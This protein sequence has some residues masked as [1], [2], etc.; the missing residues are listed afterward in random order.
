MSVA[1]RFLILILALLMLIT[2]MLV[3]C[4]KDDDTDDEEP[5]PE[6]DFS[7]SI[8]GGGDGG[9]SDSSQAVPPPIAEGDPN[10][11]IEISTPD[12]LKAIAQNGTYVLVND[13]DMTGVDFSPLGNYQYPFKGT[14]KSSD[15]NSF[16]I[17]N[18]K[19]SVSK[20]AL[21]PTATY[22]YVYAGLF[23]ATNGATISNVNFS[24]ADI[25]ATSS[26]EYSLVLSGILAGYMINTSVNNCNVGGKVYSSSKL[27][28]AYA[29]AFSG[30]LEGGS[31]ENS[32][33]DSIIETADS[34]NRAVSGGLA[35]LSLLSPSVKHCVA[36]GT[37]K[38]V[39]SYG[40]SYAGGLV[41]N[42][43]QAI[44]TACRSEADVYAETVEF[45]S[46]EPNVGAAYAG[47]I[48]AV[49]SAV[50]ETAKASFTRCY[51][52]DNTVTAVGN[53]CAAYAGGIAAYIAF[54]DLTH[55]YSLA[56]VTLKG[57]S[58]ISYASAGLGLISTTAGDSSASDYVPDFNVKG[59]FAYGN[60]TV[61]HSN[62]PHVLIG[63]LYAHITSEGS[64]ASIKNS[65]Y[66]Q[67][68][69]Y[70]LNGDTNPIT[71][72]KNGTAR[73]EGYF[74]YS[75]IGDFGWDPSEWEEVD[76]YLIAK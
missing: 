9:A 19:V 2:P 23:G 39:S 70:S 51:A 21:G 8:A 33:S 12:Q 45:N 47:G 68:A 32:G 29:G 66:N 44:F 30:I 61:E 4:N 48:A 24:E 3:S 49:T 42:T 73:L 22:T 72:S 53:E 50:N 20:A 6:D 59:C 62:I 18:L 71:L 15:G 58:R 52:L 13:I 34:K 5:N 60:V 35:G 26:D 69:V 17:K 63:T 64:K 10:A 40:L 36:K 7:G 75:N 27:F 74:G 25:S 67:S 76:G 43:R 1:K 46:K 41:G 55:C 38:A 14:L 11:V 37:V 28:N 56:N 54:T 31:L 16:T 65:Y 57:V